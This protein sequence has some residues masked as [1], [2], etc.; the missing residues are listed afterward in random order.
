MH[1]R[2]GSGLSMAT[3]DERLTRA[4]R[5]PL[6]EA[7][8]RLIA[9]TIELLRSNDHVHVTVREIA[10]AAGLNMVHITRYFGSRAELFYAVAEELHQRLL[11]H[12]RSASPAAPLAIL[13]VDDVRIRLHIAMA[14]AGEGFDMTRFQA[15]QQEIFHTISEHIASTRELPRE[16]AEVHGMKVLMLLQT[17]H[18]MN[19]ANGFTAEQLRRVAMLVNEEFAVGNHTAQRLGWL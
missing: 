4:K 11:D 3:P 17:M 6:A 19:D 10:A 7:Q 18:L 14:L 9:A 12:I 15:S 8:G 2:V 16:V 13:Q 5:V 1:D